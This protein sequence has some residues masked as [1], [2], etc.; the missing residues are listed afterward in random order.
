[1]KEIHRTEIVLTFRRVILVSL[2]EPTELAGLQPERPP[3]VMVN[4][5]E[6][7]I[8]SIERR[9]VIREAL[10]IL[11]TCLDHDPINP[12]KKRGCSK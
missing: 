5:S 6:A 8:D 9:E 4:D 3:I 12:E 11:A 7:D 1:V 2:D 10:R